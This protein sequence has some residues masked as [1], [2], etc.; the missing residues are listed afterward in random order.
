MAIQL[1]TTRIAAQ[2]PAATTQTDVTSAQT[3]KTPPLLGGENLT[4]TSGAMSDLEKLVARLK[5]ETDDVKLSVTQRRISELQT[6]LDSL[7]EI[8][9][10]K[11]R[12]ALIEI[13]TLNCEKAEAAG[14]LAR[15]ESQKTAVEGRIAA[16]DAKIAEL[17]SAVQRAVQEGKDHRELVAKLK[18]QR[19]EEQKKLDQVD[20]AISSVNA[21]ISGIDVKI[22]ECSK[23]IAQT[24]LN[25]VANALRVA[26]RDASSLS[27]KVEN[28][29]ESDADRVREEERA[30]AA[31]IG[32]VI[33]EALDKI[34]ERILAALDEA[35][36][37]VEG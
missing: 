36:M 15:Y 23:S 5:N 7:P 29:T 11:E 31:D 20:A 22:A 18:A 19:A 17:E 34:D 13:E 30:L 32:N 35:Q 1:D 2:T 10:E 8:I 12:A 9:A 33:R 24:T 37:R 16:L 4:V 3:E 21:K 25:A 6:V 28:T 27:S 26:S 14:E